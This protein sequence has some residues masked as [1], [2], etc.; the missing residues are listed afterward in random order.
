MS[1]AKAQQ[2]VAR[3]RMDMEFQTIFNEYRPR[4]FRYLARLVG[5]DEAEDLTQEVF[6]KINRGLAGFRAESKLSTW[7]FRIATNAAMDLRRRKGMIPSLEMAFQ[8][9]IEDD[10]PEEFHAAKGS[11]QQGIEHQ[12]MSACIRALLDGLPEKYRTILLLGEVE[13]FTGKEIGEI[14]G[15]NLTTVKMRLH[16]GKE[17][18]RATINRNCDISLDG[19]NE[20]VCDPK[21]SGGCPK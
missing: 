21:K 1:V 18:L 17:R 12:E 5:Q 2:F 13:G 4:I 6:L 20:V 14:L 19:R 3:M 9:E 11:L 16:R 7:I 8:E 15:L 10:L